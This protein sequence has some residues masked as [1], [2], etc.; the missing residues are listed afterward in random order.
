LHA[1]E[2]LTLAESTFVAH[3]SSWLTYQDA[4][5]DALFRGFQALL[6]L[7]KAPGEVKTVETSGVLKD[8]G[9]LLKHVDFTSAYPVLAA[10]L[11]AVHNRRSSLPSAH[12]FDKKTGRKARPLKPHE[13]REMVAH[14]A[15]AYTEIIRIATSLGI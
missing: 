9:G 8:Y 6:M 14:L 15:A 3:R 13:Q 10:H 4:F 5:N 7:K 12:P 11:Y 1:H 2:I